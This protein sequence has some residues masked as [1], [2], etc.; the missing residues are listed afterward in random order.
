MD[1][2]QALDIFNLGEKVKE[3]EQN[4]LEYMF[5]V[6]TSPERERERDRESNGRTSSSNPKTGTGQK[7]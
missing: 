5:G 4:Y 6:Q 2:R 1:I 3:Y 7:S